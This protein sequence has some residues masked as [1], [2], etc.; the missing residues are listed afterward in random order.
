MPIESIGR[1]QAF[2]DEL[3]R[4]KVIQAAGAYL[5]VSFV[6]LQVVDAAFDLVFTDPET[7]GRVVLI[8]LVLGFP[9]A[10]G[11]A[12]VFQVSPPRFTKETPRP[13]DASAVSAGASESLRR[14]SIAV[15][16]F[17]NLS[18]D[19]TN[20]YFSD[21]ITDD[22][23]TSIAHIRGLRVLSR[24]SVVRFAGAGRS[25]QEIASRLDTATVVLGSV[26]RVGSRVRIVAQ[27]VDA[28]TDRHLWSETYDRELEDIFHVQSEVAERIADA[29]ARELPTT[30]RQRIESRGTTNPEAYDLYLRGRYLWNRRT[31][32]AVAEAIRFFQH[33]LEHDPGF[34][35]AHAAMAEAHT[36]MLLYGAVAPCEV[37]PVAQ[38]AADAALSV[39]SSLGEAL[40]AK[41]CL[42]GIFGWEW[43]RAEEMYAK[44][45][46]LAPSYATA[47]QWY[48]LNL[49]APQGRFTDAS[50][51]LEL[52]GSLDPG[53]AAISASEGV[54]AF[55]A[56]RHQDGIDILTEVL[57]AHPRF[58]LAQYFLG[59]C[60]EQS[61]ETDRAI[62]AH[63]RAVQLA[64]ESSETLAALA[65]A[66]AQGGLEGRAEALLERLRR[67][68]ER[69][70]V[71]RALLAQILIGL[72]RRDDAIS[73]LQL[74]V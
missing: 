55:Y 44:A 26:R 14:D 54:L 39:D 22:I 50:L 28:T 23:I 34:A 42:A 74:A 43:S 32:S 12:W 73:E 70:Y 67:R 10:L 66:S 17:E 49:L 16:P 8:A 36:A 48:A 18:D 5:V 33:S 46:E 35:M 45:I 6:V 2:V 25:V 19:P 65:H 20:A 15:L 47:H 68:R 37:A 41:A 4:R 71:S 9:V 11:V 64:E 7:A 13:E 51:Q 52:A 58:G 62:D 27:V 40:A 59:L 3:R 38:A 61:G 69:Q 57:K 1:V 30:D 29:V 31:E 21:G 53:S 72:G 56:R 60:Y 24:A 63:S